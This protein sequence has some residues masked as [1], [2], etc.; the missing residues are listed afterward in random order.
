[1]IPTMAVAM[2]VIGCWELRTARAA[3]PSFCT[4]YVHS[5]DDGPVLTLF[6]TEGPEVTVPL[7]ASLPKNLRVNAFSP[8]GKVIYVQ[9]ASRW[10]DG[11]RKIEF[12]P[13]VRVSSPGRSDW[14]QSNLALDR[15]P[16]VRKDVCLQYL[17]KP[18]Q[19]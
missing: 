13:G 17:A 12:N 1:L 8:D 5:G 6:P 10:S 18:R 15:V 3:A 14:V 19:D 2:A 9:N 11:I 7:P 4:A 16:T